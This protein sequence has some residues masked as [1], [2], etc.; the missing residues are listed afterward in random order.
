MLCD[1]PKQLG[2]F[3]S[4]EASAVE[5]LAP[6]DSLPVDPDLVG[7]AARLP[8]HVRFG[9]TS[10]TFRGWQGIVYYRSDRQ[11]TRYSLGEYARH[12]LLTTVCMDRAFYTPLT[13]DDLELY[14]GQLP[15]GFPCVSKVWNEL[16]TLVFPNHA[17]WGDRAG[18]V[19][20]NFLDV[21]VFTAK[22]AEPLLAS[23]RD[24]VGPLIL[25]ISPTPHVPDTALFYDRLARFLDG[26]PR[27]LQFGVELRERRLFTPRYLSILNDAGAAH[28]FNYWTRMPSLGDQLAIDGTMAAP[29]AV[30]RLM[31]PPGRTYEQMRDLYEPFDR[32]C[33][34]QEAMR[35]DVADLVRA[36]Q[37]R[38]IPIYVLA[39]NKAE[40][41]SPLTV[42]AL[43]ER[44]AG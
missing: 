5:G 36:A 13:R 17:R 30:V 31:L 20:R 9:T 29:F 24:H 3:G 14:A 4:D 12:P 7:L 18:T 19:N 28:V 23:F 1:V 33:E 34:V 2:L 6:L 42:R 21:E 32:I 26:A 22:V 25:Q 37:E 11:F 15:D 40:G 41:S 8:P 27:G 16:T 38:D 44:I 10:W 43:A 39:N 35:A